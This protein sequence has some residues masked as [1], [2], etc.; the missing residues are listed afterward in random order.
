MSTNNS[1]REPNGLDAL[2][3]VGSRVAEYAGYAIIFGSIAAWWF[4][5]P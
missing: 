3:Y 4:I 5:T 2:A 1:Q